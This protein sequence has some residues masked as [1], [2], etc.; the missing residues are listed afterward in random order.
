MRKVL[1]IL[2]TI[3][4][5]GLIGALACYMILLL[6]APQGTP[7]AYADLRQSIA[8]VSS[9]LLFPSLALAVI[10]GLIAM[11]AHRPF[12]NKRWVWAKAASGILMFKGVMTVVGAKADHAAIVAQRIAAG[13]APNEL[14]ETAIAYEW[15][16]LWA[17]MALSVA[18]VVV[19]VWRPRRKVR[20]RPDLAQIDQPAPSSAADGEPVRPAA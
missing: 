4:A 7:A 8:A 15:Y 12:L 3:A 2:H 17:V 14:L 9:Y 6:F 11:A 10:S 16:A 19:G 20:P 1:K 5:C 18:N 13:E